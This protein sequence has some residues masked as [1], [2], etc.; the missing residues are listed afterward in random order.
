MAR[1]PGR[2]GTAPASRGL[3]PKLLGYHL[4]RAQTAMFQG[5][6][7]AVGAEEEITPGLFGML[8]MIAANPG[9]TQSRLSEAMHVDR[10]T[11][12]TAVDQLEGRGLVERIP[13]QQDKRSHS[14]CFTA[15]G[16]RAVRRME[17]RVLRHEAEFA[18]VLSAR[19]RETLVG[20]L[21]RLYDRDGGKAGRRGRARRGRRNGR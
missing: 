13:S 7:E 14:L 16:K 18:R 2:D 9:L 20:L 4:R 21:V 17:Q 19:E 11:I 12:V 1:E 5:F 15:R 10:S 8:Q 6:A 3:L